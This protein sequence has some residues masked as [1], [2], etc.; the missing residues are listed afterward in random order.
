[1]HTLYL[2][3]NVQS[4][5]NA[6]KTKKHKQVLPTHAAGGEKKPTCSQGKQHCQTTRVLHA[7]RFERKNAREKHRSVSQ[8]PS[9]LI[10]SFPVRTDPD[11]A[12]R[13]R[14]LATRSCPQRRSATTFNRNVFSMRRECEPFCTY[15]SPHSE[16][17][18]HLKR[19]PLPNVS[20]LSCQVGCALLL[21]TALPRPS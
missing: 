19:C 21:A 13:S 18:P 16:R 20:S 10:R 3:I 6:K 17:S 11:T 8:E 9:T 5:P 12:H 14:S 15:Q 4:S 2:L 1:M 7:P